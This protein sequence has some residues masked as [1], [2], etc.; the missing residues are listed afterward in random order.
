METPI[1]SAASQ[2][3]A[4]RTRRRKQVFAA[5]LKRSE[6]ELRFDPCPAPCAVS[7]LSIRSLQ[8]LYGGCTSIKLRRLRVSYCILA[9]TSQKRV[10]P[11][12]APAVQQEH[13]TVSRQFLK[14]TRPE[15]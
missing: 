8:T 13:T 14:S 11:W 1:A 15:T 9:S 5:R 3:P 2:M 4:R 10:H 6:I 7:R 12:G